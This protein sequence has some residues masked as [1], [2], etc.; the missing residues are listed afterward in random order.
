MPGPRERACS[1]APPPCSLLQPQRDRSPAR[2][3]GA[4]HDH[5]A[6]RQAVALVQL[7]IP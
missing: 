2:V 5:M 1:S 4:Q 6:A 3:V 7:G